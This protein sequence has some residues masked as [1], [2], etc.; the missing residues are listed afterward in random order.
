MF[1]CVY[2][3]L[4]YKRKRESIKERTAK[5]SLTSVLAPPKLFSPFTANLLSSAVAALAVQ[6]EELFVGLEVWVHFHRLD[7][8]KE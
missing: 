6:P 1:A 3:N 7:G 2:N 5:Q 4:F 8:W